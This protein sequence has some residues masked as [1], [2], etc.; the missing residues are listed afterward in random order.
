MREIRLR[1]SDGIYYRILLLME[2]KSSS[3]NALINSAILEF[4]DK[5]KSDQ[6]LDNNAQTKLN[7]KIQIPLSDDEY[8][9]LK[10]RAKSHGFS[11]VRKECRYQVINSLYDEQFLNNC[12]LK[13]FKTATAKFNKVSK[14]LFEFITLF[15]Q[16]REYDFIQSFKGFEPIIDEINQALE[17]YKK[18]LDIISKKRQNRLK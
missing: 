5:D 15:K 12:E 18:D 11:S 1:V 7:H 9:L 10:N 14:D 3:K 4:L 16:S 2:Q 17:S 8:N 13:E 6:F